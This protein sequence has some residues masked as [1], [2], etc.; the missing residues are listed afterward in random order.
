M[1][2]PY[3]IYRPSVEITA[4]IEFQWR[5]GKMKGILIISIIIFNKYAKYKL[6]NMIAV[7]KL[8]LP[9]AAVDDKIC[10]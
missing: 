9:V 3:L 8:R 5:G 7:S 1:L 10:K 4:L 2:Q 6:M